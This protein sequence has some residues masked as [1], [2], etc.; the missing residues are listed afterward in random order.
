MKVDV[1]VIEIL[2][3]KS[4][5]KDNPGKNNATEDPE[6]QEKPENPLI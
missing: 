5:V 4:D 1:P 6:N 3:T 2:R